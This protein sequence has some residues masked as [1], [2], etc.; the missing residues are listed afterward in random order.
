MIKTLL[1][2]IIWLVII[3]A[4]IAGLLLY[5]QHSKLYPSTDDA[6]VNANVIHI[7]PQVSGP[8]AEIDAQNYQLVKKGQL[9]FMI[10]P[11]PFVIAVKSA[12]AQLDL[13]KQKIAS[14]EASVKEATAEVNARQSELALAEKNQHRI[15]PLVRSGQ[16]SK[17]AGD[18]ITSKAQVAQASLIA[19]QDQLHQAKA[20]LGAI[21]DKNAQIRAAQAVLA[22]AQL[23]LSYTKVVAPSSG[24]L[25]NFSI[26]QGNMVE[27]GQ[28][29]FDIVQSNT[30]WV[31]ANFKE[32]QL[33]RI[34][35]GQPA[36]IVTDMYPNH[37]F[38][39]V[40]RFISPGSGAAFSILPPENATGNWVKVTQRFPIKVVITDTSLK[41]PL[42]VGAS[43]TVS[44]DTA[45]VRHLNKS[46]HS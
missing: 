12:E 31:D 3:I 28:P 44:I 16:I 13:T 25:V 4:I 42:R 17:Q 41:F 27:A 9:L 5:W 29:L 40:V 14:L 34:T 11:R 20:E 10:D 15:M 46:T 26:R 19:A 33:Q 39:G 18:D 1:K 32:T 30:W 21:G 2:S 45:N 24:I 7:A 36:T 22:K 38:H 6:Y 8:I 35:S 43:A 37:I 23:N